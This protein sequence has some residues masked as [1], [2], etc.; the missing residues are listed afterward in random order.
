MKWLALGP[1]EVGK[2]KLGRPAHGR[3]EDEL[4]RE[5]GVRGL[6]VRGVLMLVRSKVGL[7]VQVS[8][9]S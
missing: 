2:A 9:L 5:F 6:G 3:A 1:G 8:Q 7:A 4:P